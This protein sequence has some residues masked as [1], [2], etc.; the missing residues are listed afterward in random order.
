MVSAEGN[1][2]VI[3][4]SQI[5]QFF[6]IE[7]ICNGQGVVVFC[8]EETINITNDITGKHIEQYFTLDNDNEA[9]SLIREMKESNGSKFSLYSSSA[10][11]TVEGWA[12]R[13]EPDRHY[14][15]RG[16]I[17]D[18]VLPAGKFTA[19]NN[20]A[21]L[22]LMDKIFKS[23]YNSS[24][25]IFIANPAGLI[26]WGNQAFLK[27]IGFTLPEVIGKRL[28]SLIYGPESDMVSKRFVDDKIVDGEPF[29]FQNI[30]YSK[31][32]RTFSFMATVH[33]L[34]GADRQIIGRFSNLHDIQFA[35]GQKLEIL[36]SQ[37]ELAHIIDQEG[38]RFWVFYPETKRTYVDD[39][40]KE[41]I[42]YDKNDPFDTD[43]LFAQVHPDDAAYFVGEILPKATQQNPTFVFEHRMK[44]KDGLYRYY[45]CFIKAVSWNDSGEV[46]KMVGYTSDN[47][48]RKEQELAMQRYI[49]T[50]TGLL[51]NLNDCIVLLNDE[52]NVIFCNDKVREKLL[53]SGIAT[54][55]GI[56]AANV[57]KTLAKEHDAL[58]EQI[59]SSTASRSNIEKQ[60][61]DSPKGKNY[62][63]SL[64]NITI[65]GQLQCE[66]LV[67][68]DVTEL[69]QLHQ[70]IMSQ[71]DYYHNV[72]HSLPFDLV[73]INR[74]HQFVFVNKHGIKDD[75][76]RKAIIGKTLEDYVNVA[77]K[78]M[79][80]AQERTERFKL[81]LKTR[82]E[83]RCI[84]H[85]ELPDG[86]EKFMLRIWHPIPDANGE[87][88][89]QI[90]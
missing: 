87:V 62:E 82:E 68:K 43:T 54:G 28:H 23:T 10:H 30:G 50:I 64:S 36:K 79:A 34:F 41:I 44:N 35:S 57:I 27:L 78:P 45:S 4:P 81:V 83:Q 73:V 40:F 31:D 32:G 29:S 24:V 39:D 52:L 49:A 37:S 14:H 70:D 58:F 17:V 65:D 53:A 47:N 5:K 21:S 25:C 59:K 20:A 56:H 85:F 6:P 7:F 22:E 15:F 48:K 18:K 9:G 69:H 60:L 19:F 88:D 46:T 11:L 76:R 2:V 3:S 55:N 51:D 80:L 63:F 71:R 8:N 77:G 74:N 26:E 16:R 42:G 89:Y 84:E 1:S 86:E 90:I 66:L 61:I 75:D 12:E 72:L 13:T 33:P 67:F 38:K